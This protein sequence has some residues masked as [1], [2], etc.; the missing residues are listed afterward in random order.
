MHVGAVIEIRPRPSAPRPRLRSSDPVLNLPAQLLP[1]APLAANLRPQRCSRMVVRAEEEGTKV[2]TVRDGAA[3]D[4]HCQHC[5][6]ST[7]QQ[8][9]YA[10]S[11]TPCGDNH[12]VTADV[13]TSMLA[14]LCGSFWALCAVITD[15][16][17]NLHMARSASAGAVSS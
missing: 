1:T 13:P 14:N 15:A 16:L 9:L 17:A 2:S 6:R 7:L 3:P 4:A 10:N 8:H 5:S 12:I 11:A